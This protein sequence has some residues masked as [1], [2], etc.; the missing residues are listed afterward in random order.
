MRVRNENLYILFYLLHELNIKVN[1]L[2]ATIQDVQA[3]VAA[4]SSVDDSVVTLLQSIVQQLKDAQ[5]SNDPAAL[6]AVVA[7]IQANTKKLS[8]AVVANTPAA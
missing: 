3:A 6:D 8:D 5:A 1:I 4:E 2:M 7:S